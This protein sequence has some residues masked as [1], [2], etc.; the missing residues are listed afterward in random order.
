MDFILSNLDYFAMVYF[1][2]V[3]VASAIVKI[4]PVLPQDHWALPLVKLLA[5][6]VA[7]NRTVVNK[8]RPKN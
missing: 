2:V 1:A 3:G 8:D 5:R 6:F 4:L 7:L